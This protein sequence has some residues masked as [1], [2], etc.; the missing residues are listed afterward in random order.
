MKVLDRIQKLLAKAQSTQFQEEAELYVQK[1][2]ELMTRHDIQESQLKPASSAKVLFKEYVIDREYASSRVHFLASIARAVGVETIWA[3]LGRK[4]WVW[5]Y[6][7]ETQITYSWMLYD[8]L[9]WPLF[10]EVWKLQGP[11]TKA[12]RRL[13]CGYIAGFGHAIEARIREA[14]ESVLQEQPEAV[15]SYELRTV[16]IQEQVKALV[17]ERK[18]R[19]V[20]APPSDSK[21]YQAGYEHGQI[22][23]LAVGHLEG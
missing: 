8:T 6:G 19:S 9:R 11:N 2:Q 5:L 22:V 4:Y 23:T 15:T 10:A 1:A 12:T 7:E 20:D 16:S 17:D 18:P 13:R 21:G 14:R 3:N